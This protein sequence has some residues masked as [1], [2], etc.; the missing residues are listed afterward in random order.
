MPDAARDEPATLAP[1]AVEVT[2]GEVVESLHRASCAVA[3]AAG[4][5]VRQWGDIAR[6][7]YPRSA[8]KPLQALP[9]VETGAAVGFGLGDAEIALACASH[10][11]EAF[12]ID[13]VE[14]WLM[15]IG[16]GEADLECGAHPPI[17]PN[18]ARA[19]LGGGGAPS[20]VHNNCSGKHLGFLT[21]ARHLGEPTAGYIGV[22]HPVQRRVARTIGDLAGV[23][24][25]RAPVAV[26]GCGIPTI[27]LPLSGLATAMARFGDPAG[28]APARAAA[29]R[30]VAAAMAARPEM[31]AGT[32]RFCTAVIAESGGAML[33]KTGAEGVY[34]AALPARGLGIA[35]KVD[36][37]AG[38]AAEVALAGVLGALGALDDGLAER[39]ADFVVAP[40]A[41]HAGRRV[42]VVR[43]A[44]GWAR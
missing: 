40:L 36:D 22:D 10:G 26:D 19:L 21:T 5:L 9:L 33:A 11:G 3:D 2:R 31:V 30:R 27:A 20:Q 23:D 24:I 34:A 16:L 25:E 42:G 32:G 1:V 18:A 12:H 43:P 6:P 17:H 37:G 14:A 38:R 44:A 41:N 13:V 35:L 7:V 4:R 8:I 39:L 28:L 29:A 15:R